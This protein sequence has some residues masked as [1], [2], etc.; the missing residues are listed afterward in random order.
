MRVLPFLFEVTRD[1]NT[2]GSSRTGKKRSTDERDGRRE[3]RV[4]TVRACDGV[5]VRLHLPLAG[6][7]CYRAI[8]AFRESSAANLDANR[9]WLEERSSGREQHVRWISD[10]RVTDAG[11]TTASH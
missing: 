11:D 10:M 8:C 3:L 9:S 2:E 1:G 4:W 5:R 7:G 6:L